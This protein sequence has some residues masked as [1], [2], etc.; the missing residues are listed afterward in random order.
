MEPY[1][2]WL[3]SRLYEDPGLIWR[4]LKKYETPKAL[5]FAG[6][7]A[8]LREFPSNKRKLLSLL[9]SRKTW[10]SAREEELLSRKGIAFASF[11]D[12]AYPRRLR[13]IPDPPGGLYFRGALPPDEQP[14]VAVVGARDCSLY[15]RQ[16]A[17]WFGEG[18]ALRGVQVL[19]GM[20]RGIDACSHEGALRAE[21]GRTFAVLGGGADICY[22]EENR[23]IYMELEHRGGLISESPPGVRPL[24][25]L[26]PLRNR[27]LSG[28]SDAVLIIEAREKSGSLITADL[29]LEQ[30]REVYAVPGPLG[31]PLSAGCHNLV[32]QGAGL[33]LSPDKLLEDLEILPGIHMKKLQKNKIALERSENL[34]YSCLS[35][36]AQ[37]LEEL[38]RKTG[39]APAEALSIAARLLLKGY[40]REVS[41][42]YYAKNTAPGA[43]E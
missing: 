12:E 35:L 21:G 16:V 27:I 14:A 31:E 40:A 29:A 23:H 17:R 19:S 36:Q 39:M 20:A 15:G 3:C 9:E 43:K 30:G 2:H 10:D 5:Y 4:L 8:L 41:R 33:A 25:H 32:R 1:W 11:F 28:L 22:P 13:E 38:C 18:L 26:F 42:G 34:L 6:E 7:E 24:K 37:N